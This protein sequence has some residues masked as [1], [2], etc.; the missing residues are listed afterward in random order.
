MPGCGLAKPPE[1]A[2]VS[3]WSASVSAVTGWP[4]SRPGGAISLI[5]IVVLILSQCHAMRGPRAF[6]MAFAD[7]VRRLR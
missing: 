6:L 7:A 5:V 4:A 2:R 1:E 3:W